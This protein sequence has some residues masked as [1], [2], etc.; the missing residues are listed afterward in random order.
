MLFVAQFYVPMT[1]ILRAGELD[2]QLLADLG[3]TTFVESHGHSASAATINSYVGEKYNT[4]VLKAE[5]TD[6]VNIYHII[7]H[8]QEPAGFSKIIFDAA[9]PNIPGKNVAKLERIYLLKAFLGLHLGLEL[10]QFN[11]ELSRQNHQTGMWLFV[12]KENRRAIRF[13]E[14]AGFKVVGDYDF[15]LTE[16]HSNPNYQM[17]LTY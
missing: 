13:Y 11:L 9:H 2:A 15:K 3:K 5:L 16:T 1:S 7:Y 8:G 12:W 14:K 17:L 4:G 6:P 10:F